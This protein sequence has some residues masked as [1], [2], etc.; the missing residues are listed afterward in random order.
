MG[1]NVARLEVS[2]LSTLCQ[3]RKQV[4]EMF[5]LS[6]ETPSNLQVKAQF[7]LLIRTLD[8]AEEQLK[9]FDREES[10]ARKSLRTLS[11]DVKVRRKQLP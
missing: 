11:A 1:S 10:P 3:V 6:G 4:P 8:K 2:K 9:D 5:P 7:D